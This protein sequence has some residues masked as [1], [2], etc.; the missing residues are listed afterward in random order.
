[1][2][3]KEFK[4]DLNFSLAMLAKMDAKLY[5]A[6]PWIKYWFLSDNYVV[7]AMVFVPFSTFINVEEFNIDT[8]KC[9]NKSIINLN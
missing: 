1:M 7:S 4:H 2:I 6:C 8:N 5:D 3:N 9:I